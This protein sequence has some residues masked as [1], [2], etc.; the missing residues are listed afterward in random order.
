MLPIVLVVFQL[1]V[2]GWTSAKLIRADTSPVEKALWLAALC[3]V[4]GL[5]VWYFANF[6]YPS[7]FKL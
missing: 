7:G 3:G 2:L 4:I 5:D 6:A 1:A